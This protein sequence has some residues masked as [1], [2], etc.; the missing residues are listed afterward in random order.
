[1][2]AHVGLKALEGSNTLEG[3]TIPYDKLRPPG[4]TIGPEDEPANDVGSKLKVFPLT[5][6][7]ESE[8][9]Q[10]DTATAVLSEADRGSTAVNSVGRGT[11]VT[12][13]GAL[14]WVS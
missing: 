3:L 1:M 5:V 9:P 11:L 4:T 8:P 14:F 13:T 6:M 7:H 12:G 10:D 2:K